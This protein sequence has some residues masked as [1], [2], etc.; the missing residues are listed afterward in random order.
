MR[1]IDD[2]IAYYILT[3]RCR[4]LESIIEG[5]NQ[6]REVHERE[7]FERRSNGST[8][9]LER[10]SPGGQQRSEEDM[11]RRLAARIAAFFV[12]GA[13]AA[14]VGFDLNQFQ[15]ALAVGSFLSALQLFAALL[16]SSFFLT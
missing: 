10:K 2:K 1:S 8:E 6:M 9:E 3:T 15:G 16:P 5:N 14:V 11:S 7:E 4:S 13:V 12:V